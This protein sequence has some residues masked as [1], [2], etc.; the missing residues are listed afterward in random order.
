MFSLVLEDLTFQSQNAGARGLIPSCSSS[1]QL[2]ANGEAAGDG[3]SGW[4]PATQGGLGLSSWSQAP[5][6]KQ[7]KT[8][9]SDVQILT[10]LTCHIQVTSEA[11]SLSPIITTPAVG[12]YPWGLCT[13]S[14]GRADTSRADC[15]GAVLPGQHL[16]SPCGSLAQPCTVGPVD[17]EPPTA[18]SQIP[19]KQHT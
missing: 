2:P 16:P 15:H 10:P 11:T 6:T 17:H 9:R 19:P 7:N 3:S 1:C 18:L 8:P 5:P 12:L 13:P 4:V 14:Q